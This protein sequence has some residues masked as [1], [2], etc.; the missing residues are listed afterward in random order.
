MEYLRSLVDSFTHLDSSYLERQDALEKV[1]AFT[2][3]DE[4]KKGTGR[5]SDLGAPAVER[6]TPTI[7]TPPTGVARN[8][9]EYVLTGGERLFESVID[10]DTSLFEVRLPT[11]STPK[12]MNPGVSAE[13]SPSDTVWETVASVPTDAEGPAGIERVGPDRGRRASGLFKLTTL[14]Y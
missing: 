10:P 5:K 4:P 6:A 11:T 7:V 3:G 12:P 13:A 14:E 9:K 2:G 1:R 8:S